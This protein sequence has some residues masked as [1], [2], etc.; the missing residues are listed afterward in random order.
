[1]SPF[2][3][4]GEFYLS[5]L[6]ILDRALTPAGAPCPHT[7]SRDVLVRSIHILLAQVELALLLSR[8]GGGLGLPAV[9]LTFLSRIDGREC[10]AAHQTLSVEL[11]GAH[12]N[13]LAAAALGRS[14]RPPRRFS[15]LAHQSTGRPLGVVLGSL[16]GSG[17]GTL[18]ERNRP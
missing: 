1:V 9:R 10:V 15:G 12:S 11:L 8:V 13:D 16:I 18:G 2:D 6:G 17:S 7:S 14:D 3:P 5:D 4:N